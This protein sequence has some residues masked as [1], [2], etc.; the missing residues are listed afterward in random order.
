M[1]G[2]QFSIACHLKGTLDGH[3]YNVEKGPHLTS[4]LHLMLPREGI[5]R[6]VVHD[7]NHE[8]LNL[9]ASHQT[10]PD[11]TKAKGRWGGPSSVNLVM[12]DDDASS[13][14]TREDEPRFRHRQDDNALAI[15]DDHFRYA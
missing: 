4:N 5:Q 3:N 14:V 9:G 8:V 13:D 2:H 15:L 6:C 10:E 1:S 12:R 7:T 11:A